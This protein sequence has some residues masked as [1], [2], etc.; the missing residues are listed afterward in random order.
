MVSSDLTL[1]FLLAHHHTTEH[2]D[3]EFWERLGQRGG[4]SQQVPSAEAGGD[5]REWEK[6]YVNS[7][8]LYK[9]V[10]PYAIPLW[11]CAYHYH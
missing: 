1:L 10:Y 8:I 6:E 7:M 11:Q 4:E 3:T 2:K 9:Y 5:D